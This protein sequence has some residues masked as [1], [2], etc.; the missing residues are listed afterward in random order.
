MSGASDASGQHIHQSA[1]KIRKEDEIQTEQTVFHN[2]GFV[3][4]QIKQW[5]GKNQ[6]DS[7]HGSTD[8]S[9][10]YRTLN[11]YLET[12]FEFAR[13]GV[14]ADEAYGC[15]VEGV[16]GCVDEAFEIAGGGVACHRVRTEGVDGGLDEDVRDREHRTLKSCRKSDAGNLHRDFFIDG[17]FL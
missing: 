8:D 1:G 16:H 3:R 4:V 14:L 5:F 9:N 15:L 2:N 11:Q 7:T 12:T 6:A 17:K 10:Q 13:A